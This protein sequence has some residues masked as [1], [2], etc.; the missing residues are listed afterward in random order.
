[1]KRTVMLLS[2]SLMA[3]VTNGCTLTSMFMCKTPDVAKKVYDNSYK[4]T[5]LEKA[6]QCYK[7]YLLA[8]QEIAEVR[9]ANKVCK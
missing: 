7:N 5:A 4:A 2:V 3:L 1:M 8:K 9:E 6:K